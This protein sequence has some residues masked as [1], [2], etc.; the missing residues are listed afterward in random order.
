MSADALVACLLELERHVGRGGWDQPARLFALVKTTDLLAAEPSLAGQLRADPDH[1]DALSS[2]EQDGTELR[3]ANGEDLLAA[4]ESIAWGPA[5]DGCAMVLERSFL[6]AG[7]EAELPDEP[8]AAARYVAGHP[9]R[10]DLRVIVGVTRGGARH[11]LGRH[12]ASGEL[13]SDP[14]LVPALAAALARTLE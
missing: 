12:R 8:E 5:V 3:S 1:P 2:I 11:G 13:F 4:L 7:A 9:H 6:A 14:E 10:Q